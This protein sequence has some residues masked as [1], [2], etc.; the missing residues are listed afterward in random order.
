[1][2]DTRS[3]WIRLLAANKADVFEAA[4]SIAASFAYTI[5][6]QESFLDLMF[7]G[8][9]AFCFTAG[10]GVAHLDQMLEVLAAVQLCPGKRFHTLEELVLKHAAL[11]SGCICIF[12]DWDE[13][14]RELVKILQCWESRFWQL[15]WWTQGKE[16]AGNLSDSPVPLHVIDSDKVQEGLLNL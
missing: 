15:W 1:M 6:T 12:L 2:S 11:L 16:E 3:S 4:V 13:A 10:R 8:S 9:E 5:N 7:V 14:R